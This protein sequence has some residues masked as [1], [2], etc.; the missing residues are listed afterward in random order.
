MILSLTAAILLPFILSLLITPRVIGF[1]HRIGATD[2]P[3]PRKVH[4]V[5]MPRIGGMAILLSGAV[6]IAVLGILFP[7]L[8]QSVFDVRAKGLT[9][10]ICFLLLFALGFHDDV[11]P[12][13]PGIKF[14]LQFLLASA[15][16]ISG[17]QI[18]NIS[19]PM[20]DGMLDVNMIDYPLTV[21]WIVG[22]TNAFNLIDGLDGLATG[23]A[24]IAA[25]SICIVSLM[26]G[27]MASAVI[28]LILAGSMLGFLRYNFY[29]ASIFLGDSG[30]LVIGFSLALLSIESAAKITTGMALLFPV[31]ILL[32]PITDTLVAMIRRLVGSFLSPADTGKVSLLQRLHRM[33]TPDK[34]HIHHRLLLLGFSH[35]DTVLLLYAVA[36]FFSMSAFLLIQ[37]DNL[38]QSLPLLILF[39]FILMVGIKKLNYSEMSILANGL[40]MNR[41]EKWHFNRSGSVWLVD[42]V[43]ALLA[44]GA[45][46]GLL[47]AGSIIEVYNL[48]NPWMPVGIASLQTGVFWMTGLYR[49]RMSPFGIGSMLHTTVSVFYSV[50]AV[51]LLLVLSNTLSLT[52]TLTFFLFDFYVLMTLVLGFR[53]TDE[54]L[55]FWFHRKR[56]SGERV[57]IYGAGDSGVQVL[58]RLVGS[59]NNKYKILGFLDDDPELEG[60]ILSGYPIFGGHWEL[61]KA[62]LSSRVESIIISDDTI[63]NEH[64]NRLKIVAH[65]RGISMRRMQVLLDDLTTKSIVPQRIFPNT[66]ESVTVFEEEMATVLQD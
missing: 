47:S 18:S 9:V 25:V 51:T 35:R 43:T 53:I 42:F 65:A 4:T 34:S 14:G 32:F 50:G 2:I 17:F 6:S 30:S 22:I 52:A 20:G 1:A 12:L 46:Y 36:G 8:L 13:S 33:F 40:L 49:E 48:V 24:T 11:K 29:P 39:S 38:Q 58:H 66:K 3:D 31:L 26:S 10:V 56:E 27:Q 21:L 23:V 60:T 63:K 55:K 59:A 28:S 5:P 45:T 15:L 64:L 41:L 19:N 54:A 57:L 44:Y 62:Y 16:Y 61:S 7:D 37:V